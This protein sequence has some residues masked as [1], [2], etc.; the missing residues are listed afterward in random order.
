MTQ[1][2]SGTAR[3]R[4]RDTGVTVSAVAFG[5]ASIGN[6]YRATSDAEAEQAVAAAWA[7]GI[8]YFDTA[9]HYGL[10]LSERRLG[11]ALAQ[12][13]RSAYAI[14]TK[15]GRLLVPDPD[16]HAVRDP[17]GFDVPATHRRVRDYSR[18]GV[19]RSLESSLDRLGLDRVDIVYVH[20][21]DQFW[22][23]ASTEA[24]SALVELR[25]QGV[26]GAIGVGMNQG[27]ML[28]EFVRRTDV[29]VVM[30]AGRY[31]LLE[32]GAL[33]TVLPA[34]QERG[35][36]V[37]N[38]GVFN[39]GLLAQNR[40]PQ[41]ATYNY[42]PAPARMLARAHALADVCEA[43][44]VTLPMAAAQLPLLHP[45]VV[46]VALGCRTAEHVRRNIGLFD[47]PVPDALWRDLVDQQLLRADTPIAGPARRWTS[48]HE[49]PERTRP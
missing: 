36:A 42:E 28:A 14:S 37:V 27:E 18:D 47:R 24:V 8:R 39:S 16:G 13:D 6:L 34:A 4:I 41:S 38:V 5:A 7:A 48:I 26:V 46:S 35:V 33:D 44:G 45:A 20:D 22:E 43:H 31:T 11:L 15:V 40:P 32:Q 19:R 12:Y 9:P 10:G 25:E 49:L 3:C 21:P 2:A 23:Q 29:D 1:P 30:L 17:A